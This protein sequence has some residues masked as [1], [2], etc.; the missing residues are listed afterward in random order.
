MVFLAL[1]LIA[2]LAG[3]GHVSL[4]RK[5]TDPIRR[6]RILLLYQLLIAL[7]VGGL[8]IFLGHALRPAVVAAMIGWPSNPNFQFELGSFGLG[9]AIAAMLCLIIDDRF[10]WLGVALAPSIFMILAG[11]N[12]GRDALSGNLAPYNIVTILPDLLL[13]C[14]LGWLLIRLF[15]AERSTR[16]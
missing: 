8:F 9:I 6:I 7:G 13:P 4:Q 11:L 15:R 12:H 5:W 1:W 14:T 3:V 16:R 2:L 10:Y